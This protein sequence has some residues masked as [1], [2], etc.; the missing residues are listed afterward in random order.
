MSGIC[1]AGLVIVWFALARRE[2]AQAKSSVEAAVRQIQIHMDGLAQVR[3]G[4]YE[5]AADAAQSLSWS[6]YRK[7]VSHYE[8]C[9]YK[10]LNR[11]PALL[12]GYRSF[13]K[14]DG[15]KSCN[16]VTMS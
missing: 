15:P 13:Q 11:L 3:G 2:L 10:P 1:A 9:R 14:A 7:A 4:P 6:I 5:T 8:I 12:F 16:K